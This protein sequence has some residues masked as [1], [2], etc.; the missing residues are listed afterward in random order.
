MMVQDKV[1]DKEAQHRIQ[2]CKTKAQET[3]MQEIWICRH[4]IQ[5]CKT[6]VRGIWAGLAFTTVQDKGARQQEHI[7]IDI[8]SCD[9]D[10]RH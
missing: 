10:A 3:K 2:R 1:Q 7:R 4:T 8:D 5:R 6:N 9:K